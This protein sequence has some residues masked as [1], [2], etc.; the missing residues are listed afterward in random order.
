[1]KFLIIQIFIISSLFSNSFDI[2]GGDVVGKN[3]YGVITNFNKNPIQINN[4][5]IIVKENSYNGFLNI[6]DKNQDFLV[7]SFISSTG[8]GSIYITK[9]KI[10]NNKIDAYDTESL[11]LSSMGGV[12][13][14]SKAYKTS[15]NTYMFTQDKL[16]NS[17]NDKSFVS[18]FKYYFDDKISLVNSYK[19]GW[20]FE[21][22]ILN[23][24]GES[25][26]I[27]NFSMGRTFG[28]FISI[29]PDNKTV[30]IFDEK[31]SKNLYLFVSQKQQDFLKGTLY[32]ASKVNDKIQWKKLGKNSSLRLKL[33]LKKNLK[34][35]DIYKSTKVKNNKCPN[36]YTFISTVYGEEC[37]KINKKLKKYAGALEPIRQ[38]AM[39]GVKSFLN[40]ISS[41]NYDKEKNMLIFKNADSIKYR[42]NTTNNDMNSNF[43]IK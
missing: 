24:S 15:W 43:I 32:V 20:N 16:I 11:D 29:M 3:I 7:S 35:K 36:K 22:I 34:F 17:K 31:Y 18:D 33:K 13:S 39:L 2:K 27:N 38:S 10:N 14:P 1:M 4:R 19:Y 37:L 26:A 40:D 28:S 42:F 41:M 23:A 30:Y 12:Y 8:I 25:K 21:V 6:K 5:S 9:T